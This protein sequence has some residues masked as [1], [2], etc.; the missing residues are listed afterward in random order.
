[1]CR[2]KRGGD[3]SV[4]RGGVGGCMCAEVVHTRVG[5]MGECVGGGINCSVVRGGGGLHSFCGGKGNCFL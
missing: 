3:C 4:V 5:G 2:G 1:M